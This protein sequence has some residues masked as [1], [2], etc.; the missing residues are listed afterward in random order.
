MDKQGFLLLICIAS[1]SSNISLAGTPTTQSLSK[2]TAA[3]T[4]ADKLIWNLKEVDIRTVI[5]QVSKATGKN[6]IID[7][8]VSGKVT[9]ISSRPIDSNELYQVFLSMLQVNGYSA[10]PSGKVIKIVV[11][12]DAKQMATP[13]AD[14]ATPGK[15]DEMVVRVIPANNVQ[16]DKLLYVVQSLMPPSGSITVYTPNNSLIVSGTAA[17]VERIA[18]IIER[19]DNA[20]SSQVEIIQLKHIL[21]D[22]AINILTALEKGDVNKGQLSQINIVADKHSNS[23][24]LKGDNSTRQKYHSLLKQI[25]IP[26]KTAVN[27]SKVVYLHYLKA[28]DLAPILNKILEGDSTPTATSS[29]SSQGQTPPIQAS[30]VKDGSQRAV[31]QAE[32]NTNALLINAPPNVLQNILAIIGSLDIRPAQVLVEAAIV[33]VSDSVLSQLGID[34][35]TVNNPVPGN[36]IPGNQAGVNIGFIRTGSLRAIVNALATESNINILS[37]PSVVVMDNQQAKIEI[38]KTVS[39]RNTQSPGTSSGT[40][41]TYPYTTYSREKVGLHLY[42]TPQITQGNAVQLEIDQANDSLEET[43][44]KDPNADPIFDNRD[45]KT[46]VMVDNKAILVLGGLIT[47]ETEEGTQKLPL[48]GDLPG[49][50]NLFQHKV[51]KI[52]KKNLMVFLQPVILRD[53]S[54]NQHVTDKKYEFIRQQQLLQHNK[55]AS[56]LGPS[57][58]A[59]LKPL[60]KTLKLPEP[61]AQDKQKG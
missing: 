24:L 33:E 46:T 44:N 52:Q 36:P 59:T 38:G 51:R 4:R 60:D 15:G 13:F 56:W 10:I 42:V 28:K 7:P 41:T 1:L 20:N 32:P 3:V 57:E 17:N 53:Q 5:E 45:I 54:S 25:D 14:S 27:S 39:V 34:W 61:F 11:A 9:I 8:R 6:F 12:N 29:Q 18:Q 49:V 30:I 48:L 31:I 21:V 50:G 23:V 40:G 47:S 26:S 55:P 19:I 35:Q 43:G 16:A 2:N 37:T 58:I 22:D